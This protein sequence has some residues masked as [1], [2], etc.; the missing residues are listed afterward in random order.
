MTDP[1]FVYLIDP[2]HGWL[3]VN[4]SDIERIGMKPEE[5]SIYSYR[6]KDGVYALEHDYDAVRFIGKWQSEIGEPNIKE[7][8]VPLDAVVRRWPGIHD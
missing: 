6:S 4:L 7:H 2:G 1:Q 8:H 5:F 3:L